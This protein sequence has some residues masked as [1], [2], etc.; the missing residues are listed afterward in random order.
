M[1]NEI[2]V[3]R[4]A[5]EF[6]LQDLR[7]QGDAVVVLPAPLRREFHGKPIAPTQSSPGHIGLELDEFQK[8]NHAG[9]APGFRVEGQDEFI[10]CQMAAIG[11]PL[12]LL[13]L[14]APGGKKEHDKNRRQR[15]QE[16]PGS[17]RR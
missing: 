8:S 4:L 13:P 5:S 6:A 9:R 14:H 10:V 3:G 11:E 16:D 15:D 7:Q 1:Q 2:V 17:P 12:Q